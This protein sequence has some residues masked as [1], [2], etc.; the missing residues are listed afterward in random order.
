MKKLAVN[1]S[2]NF[3]NFCTTLWDIKQK[4]ILHVTVLK[5]L[6][7]VCVTVLWYKIQKTSFHERRKF[8]H[9]GTKIWWEVCRPRWCSKCLP[10]ASTQGVNVSVSVNVNNERRAAYLWQLRPIIVT[11]RR[12]ICSPIESLNYSTMKTAPPYDRPLIMA[13]HI[14]YGR[15]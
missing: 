5:C 6:H 8:L 11:H 9:E 10:S 12:L 3:R 14:L 2:N 4:W 15:P 1:V 13:C 7:Y